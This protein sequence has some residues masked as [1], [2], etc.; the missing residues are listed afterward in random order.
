MAEATDSAR[1]SSTAPVTYRGRVGY[2]HLLRQAD[3]GSLERGTR[4]AERGLVEIVPSA[5]DEVAAVVQGSTEYDVALDATGGTCTCPVGLRGQFCK[6][7]V[8]TVLTIEDADRLTTPPRTDPPAT[9]PTAPAPPADLA[10]LAGSL[11]IRKHL[12]YWQA[13]DH[14]DRAHDVADSSSK[15]CRPRPP[16]S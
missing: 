2:Q 5:R 15:H 13:N 3:S 4:Y 1:A 12:D 10:A 9:D 16:T 6:H 14:G 7:L 11:R 8:A